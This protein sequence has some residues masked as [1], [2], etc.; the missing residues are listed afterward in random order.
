MTTVTITSE[1][2]Q[3]T[4]AVDGGEPQPVE[5]AQAACEMA[6]QALGGAEGDEGMPPEGLT[7]EGMEGPAAEQ[8]AMNAGF[9]GVRGGGLMG[10]MMGR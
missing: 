6:E 3:V 2:G 9:A 8:D 10:G 4:V 1:N 5:S 7:S